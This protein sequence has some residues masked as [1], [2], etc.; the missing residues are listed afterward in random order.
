MTSPQR[1]EEAR[2][3][4]RRAA[5]PPVSLLKHPGGPPQLWPIHP[6]PKVQVHRS[7]LPPPS[8]LTLF[9]TRHAE[10]SAERPHLVTIVRPCGQSTLRKVTVLLN[11]RGV[12]SFEQLLLDISEA[13]GF[14]AGT[15]PE[16]HVCTRPT[17]ER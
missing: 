15:D 6:H 2:N 7:H 16:S 5:A 10:E 17:H 8:H 4:K 11:R 13:L 14:L 3:A 12:V 9:R 1:A